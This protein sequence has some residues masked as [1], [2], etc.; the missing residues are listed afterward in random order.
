MVSPS[1]PLKVTSH[2][3]KGDGPMATYDSLVWL[4]E[5]NPDCDFSFVVG[6]DWLQ[7]GT[8]IR[9]WES[10]EGVTGDKLLN[11]F[12]FLVLKRPGYEVEDL[13]AFG[14]RFT[15]MELPHHFQLIESSGSST[16]IRKRA[17]HEWGKNPDNAQALE[18]LDG[19]V[20]P[21]I[22]SFIL[23]HQLYK[24]LAEAALVRSGTKP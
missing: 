10:K 20:A 19:L 17:A 22:H 14:P 3:V 2:E 6:S 1:F 9:T 7:P 5:N 16:E 24:H 12:D 18:A 15:W 23:R 8:D 13:S 4:R 21:A 11:E